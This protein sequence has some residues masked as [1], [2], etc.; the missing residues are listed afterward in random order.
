MDDGSRDEVGNYSLRLLSS[1]TDG[2][3]RPAAGSEHNL[4]NLI[5]SGS[6][7]LER[8]EIFIGCDAGSCRILQFS[9]LKHHFHTPAD[10][11]F[12]SFAA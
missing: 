8:D 6:A 2:A 3:K 9:Y 4:G 12:I 5:K 11:R 1:D 10:A 7:L